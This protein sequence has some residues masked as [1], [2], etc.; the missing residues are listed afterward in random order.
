MIQNIIDGLKELLK[1]FD[2]VDI[3]EVDA[4]LNPVGSTVIQIE[5]IAPVNPAINDAV[6]TIDI[7]GMTTAD[8]DPD[9]RIITAL[10]S[11]VAQTL[12]ALT[13]PDIGAA[14]QCHAELWYLLSATP[15][16]G[17]EQR[18][19][20]IQYNLTVQNFIP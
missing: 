11:N 6:L 3:G 5:S 17:G 1:E 9:K 19:F 2:I 4:N 8:A 7:M 18:I 20:S 10:Y 16:S 12:A 15:P 13:V 14:C